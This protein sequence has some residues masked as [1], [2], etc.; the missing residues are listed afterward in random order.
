MARRIR[1]A[2]EDLDAERHE[3]ALAEVA[4]QRELSLA[5]QA[6]S[7]A[8]AEAAQ[9]IA[10]ADSRANAAMEEA[11]RVRRLLSA[12]VRDLE[13]LSAAGPEATAGLRARDRAS[14]TLGEL[15]ALR[16]EEAAAG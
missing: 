14:L 9:R 15:A 7:D 11:S 10:D 6:V 4:W 12:G 3:R 1:Q 5:Q 13:A 2:E 8:Q 16:A